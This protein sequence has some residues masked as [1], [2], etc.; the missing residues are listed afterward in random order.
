[1]DDGA[2]P[3]ALTMTRQQQLALRIAGDLGVDPDEVNL[4]VKLAQT[5]NVT[6]LVEVTAKRMSVGSL[7]QPVDLYQPEGCRAAPPRPARGLR[8]QTQRGA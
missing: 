3:R 1:M 5:G 7:R 6:L 2:D 4:A 8:R